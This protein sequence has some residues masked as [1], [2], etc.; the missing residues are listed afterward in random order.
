M[1]RNVNLTNVTLTFILL[2]FYVATRFD[3]VCILIKKKKKTTIVNAKG[4]EKREKER[5]RKKNTTMHSFTLVYV[6]ACMLVV[7]WNCT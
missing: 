7:T 4:D 5:M 1:Q 3:D 2:D 6:H